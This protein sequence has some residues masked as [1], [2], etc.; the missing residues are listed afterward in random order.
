MVKEKGETGR[1]SAVA[2]GYDPEKDEAPRVI[3][4]GQGA[5][6]DSLLQ[7]AKEHEIPIHTDH[8]LAEALVK[9]ELGAYVPPELY[10]AVAEVMAFLLRLEQEKAAKGGTYR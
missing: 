7:I 2:L 8:P 1:K 5:L 10:A 6:A 9:L 3:A 4:A